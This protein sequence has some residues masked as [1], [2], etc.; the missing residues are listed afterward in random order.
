[1]LHLCNS[2]P[3]FLVNNFV[4]SKLSIIL[5]Q[6]YET[7]KKDG[8]Y[9]TCKDLQYITKSAQDSMLLQDSAACT[10]KAYKCHLLP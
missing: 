5:P 3:P 4:L 10:D 9:A 1:M 2:R 8:G 7:D 6:L